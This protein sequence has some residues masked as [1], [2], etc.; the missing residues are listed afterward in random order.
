[1]L[2]TCEGEEAQGAGAG[3][4]RGAR[5]ARPKTEKYASILQKNMNI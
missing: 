1:M 5:E 3:G 4:R 2:H